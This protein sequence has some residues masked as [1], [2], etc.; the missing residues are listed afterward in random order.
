MP[1]SD[2]TITFEN[3]DSLAAYWRKPHSHLQWD[4]LFVL[5]AWL[6]VWWREFSPRA[7]LYLCAVRQGDSILGIAPLQLKEEEACFLGSADFCDCLDFVVSPGGERDFFNVLLDNLGQ[8]GIR[9]LILGP[10]R[11][12]SKT[13][14]YLVGIANERRYEVSCEVEDIS[15]ELDL[16]STWEEYLGILSSKQRHEVRRKL[17]RLQEKGEVHYRTVEGS[18]S[19]RGVIDLFLK[20]FRES[21]EDKEIFL[22]KGRE[23]FFRSLAKAM[24]KESLLSIGTLELDAKPVAVIMCFDY[25]DTVYLYNNGYDPQYRSLSI[26][27]ISKIMCIKYSIE[28]GRRKFD[29]LKGAEEYKYRLGGKE[30]HLQRCQILLR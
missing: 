3:F 9:R 18:E 4:C 27:L 14:R 29:F 11:P 13:L 2:Y 30:V 15:L 12:D 19:V 7:D 21:R 20:F 22:T 25:N 23:S 16:P 8:R 26:G 17:R 10:L 28:R 6:E 24:A 1:G 5:P